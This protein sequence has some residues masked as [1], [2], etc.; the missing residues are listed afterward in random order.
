MVAAENGYV[1]VIEL[2]LECG[3]DIN[4]KDINGYL[5]I[6]YNLFIIMVMLYFKQYINIQNS[7]IIAS[8][9]CLFV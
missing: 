5:L 6:K 7:F 8:Y 3:A 4:A 9:F 2:L 1:D